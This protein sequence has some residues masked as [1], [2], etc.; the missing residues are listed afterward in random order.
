M[1]E[2]RPAVVTQPNEA[3]GHPSIGERRRRDEREHEGKD[4]F[5]WFDLCLGHYWDTA[6]VRR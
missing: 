5:Y 6:V 1:R 2:V 4:R 3:N